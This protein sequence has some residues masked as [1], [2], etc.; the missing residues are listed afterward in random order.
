M[1]GRFGL[2]RNC[3]T[4]SYSSASSDVESWFNQVRKNLDSKGF[5]F[6][7]SLCWWIWFS[8][9]KLM[10]EDRDTQPLILVNSVRDFHRRFVSSRSIT[11]SPVSNRSNLH[12]VPP[13]I[14][15]IKIN[16]DAAVGNSVLCRSFSS[17]SACHTIRENNRA[18]LA[19]ARLAYLDFCFSPV[20]PSAVLEIVL[21]ELPLI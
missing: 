19:L 4:Q 17:F 15:Y 13:S 21:S 3:H 16:S 6:F 8:R 10:W 5:G 18:A 11:P 12:W 20:L 7:S 2:F 14:N 1:L 9:N